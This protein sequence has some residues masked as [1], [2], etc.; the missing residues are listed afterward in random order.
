[1]PTIIPDEMKRTKMM[2]LD[3]AIDIATE[4]IADAIGVYDASLYKGKDIA[5]LSLAR[6][7]LLRFKAQDIALRKLLDV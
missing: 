4:L 5:R 7:R 2:P 3:E 6:E 1:M